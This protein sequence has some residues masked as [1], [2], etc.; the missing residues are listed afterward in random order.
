MRETGPSTS[1][2]VVSSSSE[3]DEDVK[4]VTDIQAE[5]VINIFFILF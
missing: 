1:A 2:E 3:N 5:N 4:N